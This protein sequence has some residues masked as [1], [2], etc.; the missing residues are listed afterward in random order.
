[1]R[2][3]GEYPGSEY[4]PAHCRFWPA[5]FRRHGY[6]TAHIGK[7]HSGRDA[8]LSLARSRARTEH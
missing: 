5:V 1:M 7:W 6:H 8:V 3:D 2:M 4:D